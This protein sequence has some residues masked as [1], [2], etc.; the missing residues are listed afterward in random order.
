MFSKYFQSTHLQPYSYPHLPPSLQV[1]TLVSPGMAYYEVG[2]AGFGLVR[3]GLVWFG[4]VGLG[5]VGFGWVW[6]GL[7]GLLGWSVCLL[8]PMATH[9]TTPPRH[10]AA[11]PPTHHPNM[12]SP[13]P[14]R[15]RCV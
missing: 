9:A 7:V 3:F 12:P 13:L 8:L 2:L 5:L 14:H 6:L 11:T 10:H 15:G 4:L 1:V